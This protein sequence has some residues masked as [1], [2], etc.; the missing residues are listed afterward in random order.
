MKT[1]IHMKGKKKKKKSPC[2]TQK[3]IYRIDSQCKT[4]ETILKMYFFYF[5]VDKQAIKPNK[6]LI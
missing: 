4:S 6:F 1:V 5:E 2:I 3:I